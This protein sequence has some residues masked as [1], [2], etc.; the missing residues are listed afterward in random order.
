MFLAPG[1]GFVK[2]NFSMDWGWGGASGHW[3]LQDDSNPFHLL[4]TFFLLL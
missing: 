2:D 3:R 1:A 4:C